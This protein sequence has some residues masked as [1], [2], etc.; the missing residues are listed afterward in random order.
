M[1]LALTGS[2]PTSK[3]LRVSFIIPAMNEES[4]IVGAL[5]SIRRQQL[6]DD[7]TVA[8]VIVVDSGSTDATADIARAAGCIVIPAAAGNVS[9]SR[10]LGAAQASGNILAFV[11]A[12]CEL[13]DTWLTHIADEL[14]DSQVVGAGMNMAV[15]LP[16]ASWVERTWHE[17]AHRSAAV[18]LSEN[19]EWLATFNV[20][21]RTSVFTRIG[22][23]DE[24]LT[25][26]EDVD[27]GYRLVREGSLRFIAGNGVIHHGESRSLSEFFRREAWRA[28][29][30]WQL[31]RD[32]RSSPRE[33]LSCL[34]PFA[35][36]GSLLAGSAGFLWTGVAALTGA[37]PLLVLVFRKRP[38]VRLLPAAVIVQAVYFAARCWGM[39]RPAGRVERSAGAD[40][41]RTAKLPD[42][43]SSESRPVSHRNH[44]AKRLH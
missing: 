7:I 22:G 21:V 39:L 25:T 27:L 26:C 28:R 38:S 4:M 16:G 1:E 32:H 18:G 31:L 17:L 6:R 3:R 43:T 34:I 29:G 36:T 2:S 42:C 14:Q 30:G 12:D 19:A 20:A 8:E 44:G 5:D 13:P 35:V 40:C 15:P 9:A 10:N 23:F 33:L 11:D 41:T 37:V 24:T